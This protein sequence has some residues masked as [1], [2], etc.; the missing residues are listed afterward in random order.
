MEYQPSFF[1]FS[2]YKV[3]RDFA[4]PAAQVS[5]DRVDLTAY[6]Y[7]NALAVARIYRKLGQPA[8]AEEFDRLAARICAA[9]LAKMWRPETA[10]L[11]LTAGERPGGRRGQ[12]SDRCLSFLFRDGT[13]G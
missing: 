11:L 4:Q 9:V 6:N 13:L 2:D 10:I 7:G 5:L 12:G 3:S 1:F 8:K